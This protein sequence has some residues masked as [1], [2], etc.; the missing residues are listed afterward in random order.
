MKAGDQVAPNGVAYFQCNAG[1][2]VQGVT[3][4]RCMANGDWLPAVM[5]ECVPKPC[6]LP[7]LDMGNYQGG[8]RSGMS[9]N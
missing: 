8:Y 2:N 6:I 5:P 9:L 3:T 1:Y 4:L 7:R